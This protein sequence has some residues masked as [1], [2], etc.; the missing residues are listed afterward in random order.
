MWGV[1]HADLRG[2]A[3]TTAFLGW[4]ARLVGDPIA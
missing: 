4:R 3:R 2:N 1:T